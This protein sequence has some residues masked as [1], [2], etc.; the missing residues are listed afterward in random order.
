MNDAYGR[1]LGGD[2][3]ALREIIEEFCAPL[4]FYIS[5]IIGNVSAA[6]DLAEDVIVEL[7]LNHKRFRGDASLKTYLYKIARNKAVDYLRKEKRHPR[8]QLNEAVEKAE[9]MEML[10]EMIAEEESRVIYACMEK[11]APQ[12]REV[13]HLTFFEEMSNAQCAGVMKKSKKQVENLLYQAKKQLRE[14]LTQEGF[15]AEGGFG[16]EK[17]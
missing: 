9:E 15:K 6:E 13:L 8:V 10:D 3:N 7:A 17:F 2:E 4:T 14:L 5:G 12:Y 11:L 1:F 16:S